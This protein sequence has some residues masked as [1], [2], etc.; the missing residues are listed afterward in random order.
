MAQPFEL[1]GLEVAV[2]RNVTARARVR[3][4]INDLSWRPM[5]LDPANSPTDLK[6]SKALNS[7]NTMVLA[8]K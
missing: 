6:K 2:A 5:T 7:T 8:T 1:R 4:L 3:E